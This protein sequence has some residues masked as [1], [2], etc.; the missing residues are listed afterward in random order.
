MERK[1]ELEILAQPDDTTC[2]PTCLHAVY[3][4]YGEEVALQR[5]IHETA[6]LDTG[7]TLAVQLGL[8]ALRRGYA[9]EIYTYNL[10]V[11][12]P[13]WFA[14]GIDLAERLRAQAVIKRDPKLQGTTDAYLEFLSLGGSIRMDELNTHLLRRHLMEGRPILT[15][16]S[17]TYLY[18][19]PREVGETVLRYDDIHGQPTGHFV[20]LCGYDPR[21]GNVLVAD[22]LQDNPGYGAHYYEEGAERVLGAI[23]LGV[24][25]Y[26]ANLL[27]VEPAHESRTAS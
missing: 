16:L 25:T 10:V 21:S 12:D 26:D 27:I 1:L 8:H 4:Y 22:P 18:E 14:Q 13:S 20:V 11:F 9:A 5:V 2:G 24:L 6:M 17:A 15:G 19:C 3:R 23:C 7:G